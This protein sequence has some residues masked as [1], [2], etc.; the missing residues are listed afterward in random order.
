MTRNLNT[1]ILAV[2]RHNGGIANSR[3]RDRAR[4]LVLSR[5]ISPP[6]HFGL[7]PV[8][9]GDF[10]IECLSVAVATATNRILQSRFQSDFTNAFFSF[11]GLT[12]SSLG[13]SPRLGSLDL[14]TN[15][16]AGFVDMVTGGGGAGGAGSAPPLADSV[17]TCNRPASFEDL[18]AME[19]RLT[20]SF[21]SMTM[22]C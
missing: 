5:F 22:T 9:Q 11:W 21:R 19:R 8:S 3:R 1:V 2:M 15:C 13:V 20:R 12:G 18:G 4:A 10:N 7:T 6:F 17:V 14:R 16:G